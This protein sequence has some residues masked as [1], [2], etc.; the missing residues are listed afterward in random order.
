ME[1]QEHLHLGNELKKSPQRKE[2][3]NR[4]TEEPERKELHMTKNMASRWE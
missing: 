1:P 3:R 2:K 4:N